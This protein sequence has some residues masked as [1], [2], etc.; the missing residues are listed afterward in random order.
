MTI[1]ATA[2]A[3]A[4][5]TPTRAPQRRTFFR[6]ATR[7]GTPA[8]RHA[9]APQAG[10]PLDLATLTQWGFAVE[11]D[12]IAAHE[13]S[14]RTVAAAAARRG[15]KPVLIDVLTDPREPAAARTRAFG[16]LALAL[17]R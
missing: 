5:A 2:P 6:P 4:T 15:L 16:R 8:G 7:I 13:D 14:A 1:T 3:V 10:A 12:G 17:A 9:A 11:A